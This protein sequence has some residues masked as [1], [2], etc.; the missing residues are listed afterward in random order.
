MII[1]ILGPDDESGPNMY[2][3]VCDDKSVYFFLWA[4]AFSIAMYSS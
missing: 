4:L 3:D 1:I 2:D